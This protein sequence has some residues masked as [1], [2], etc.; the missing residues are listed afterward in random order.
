MQTMDGRRHGENFLH[1]AVDA[2]HFLSP[3][4]MNGKTTIA[5]PSN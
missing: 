5:K 3:H 1:L 4:T 2:A